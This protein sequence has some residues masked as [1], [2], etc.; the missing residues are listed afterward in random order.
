MTTE[1]I[2]TYSD[3][4]R[5]NNAVYGSHRYEDQSDTASNETPDSN[6]NNQKKKKGDSWTN[7]EALQLT[8]YEEHLN[9]G[10]GLGIVPIMKYDRCRFSAIDVDVYNNRGLLFSIVD[11]IYNWRLPVL[12]FYS[13]SE[14]LH[15][16][17]FY[18]DEGEKETSYGIQASAAIDYSRQ[19]AMALLGKIPE[20]FPKQ[21]K[22]TAK[23]FGNWINLPYFGA[24]NNPTPTQSLIGERHE[25]V[26]V[27]QALLHV[28]QNI[29]TKESLENILNDLPFSDGPPCLQKIYLQGS[30]E[31]TR[32]IA[33]FNAALYYKEKSPQTIDTDLR[34][35]NNATTKPLEEKEVEQTVKNVTDREYH[36]QCNEEPLC[37]NC[38]K[39]IC[40]TREFGVGKT[41]GSFMGVELG[42]LT[43]NKGRASSSYE[44]PVTARNGLKHTVTFANIEEL[45]KQDTLLNQVAENCRSL[46]AKVKEAKWGKIVDSLLNDEPIINDVLIADDLTDSAFYIRKIAER[47]MVQVTDE[48]TMENVNMGYSLY[49]PRIGMVLFREQAVW[50]TIDFVARSRNDRITHSKFKMLLDNMPSTKKKSP[51]RITDPSTPSGKRGVRFRSISEAVLEEISGKPLVLKQPNITWTMM[52]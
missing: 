6:Q 46:P 32:N 13:K 24:A 19:L 48:Q 5:G 12:P 36:Y 4:F 50:E 34:N 45:R 3:I 35:I 1:S 7:H 28:V 29:Q 26:P 47:I 27:D 20:V 51:D 22:L 10:I 41:Q 49:Q 40:A 23:S 33:L 2:K 44:L 17:S 16:Y 39:E 37:S 11:A 30:P 25:R 52:K 42:K 18:A 38:N 9:G 21:A 43:I 15:L 14:G 8:H 31:G